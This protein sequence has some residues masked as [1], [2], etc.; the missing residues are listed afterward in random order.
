MED[1]EIIISTEPVFTQKFTVLQ[2]I[3]DYNVLND[4]IGDSYGFP[5]FGTS[6]YSDPN[7]LPE[8]DG[9][10]YMVITTDVQRNHAECLTGIELIDQI[11]TQILAI[12]ETV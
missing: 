12:D 4:T 7:P 6:F 1:E 9:K 5:R 2:T 8:W 11:P 3:E 10:Y